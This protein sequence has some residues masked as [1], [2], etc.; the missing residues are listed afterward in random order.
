MWPGSAVWAALNALSL[1]PR[2]RFA[3]QQVRTSGRPADAPGPRSCATSHLSLCYRARAL[4]PS[5]VSAA[6]KEMTQRNQR[7]QP[8]RLPWRSVVPGPH[9]DADTSAY[10]HCVPGKSG[11]YDVYRVHFIAMVVSL[12]CSVYMIFVNLLK[13]ALNFKKCSKLSSL[14]EQSYPA[15]GQSQLWTQNP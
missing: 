14:G 2:G 9:G 3:G 7:H 13:F 5:G 11:H 8:G 10:R 4:H 1:A 12:T 15:Y 6:W